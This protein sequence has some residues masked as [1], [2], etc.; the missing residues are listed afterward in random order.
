MRIRLNIPE[1]LLLEGVARIHSSTTSNGE[2][3]TIEFE[4][5][6]PLI[7][8]LGA[9][10]LIEVALEGAKFV[11]EAVAAGL[12][13]DLFRTIANSI[14]KDSNHWIVWFKNL[15]KIQGIHVST[16]NQKEAERLIREAIEDICNEMISQEEHRKLETIEN[17]LR[18]EFLSKE[19]VSRTQQALRSQFALKGDVLEFFHRRFSGGLERFYEVR[20]EPYELNGEPE[21]TFLKRREN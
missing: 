1:D 16:E 9:P 11:G 13:Y 19:S 14:K 7:P 5:P 21:L 4:R 8:P 15:G 20:T 6:D 10:C 18:G 2:D 12:A 17:W 3:Y